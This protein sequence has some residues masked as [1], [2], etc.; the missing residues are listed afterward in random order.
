MLGWSL[1]TV[2]GTLWKLGVH[3]CKQATMR[4]FVWV[5]SS[6]YCSSDRKKRTHSSMQL[7]RHRG[8]HQVITGV[9]TGVPELQGNKQQELKSIPEA[10]IK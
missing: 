9:G 7:G 1:A 8:N 4:S 6:D 2:N 3:R 5:L 10:S